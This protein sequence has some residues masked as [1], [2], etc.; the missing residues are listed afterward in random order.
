MKYLL[1]SGLAIYGRR[2]IGKTYLVDET[3]KGRIMFRHAGLSLVD[4]NNKGMLKAQLEH[5]F[6]SLKFHAMK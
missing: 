3:F 2:H 5:F 6:Y 4:G 1:F